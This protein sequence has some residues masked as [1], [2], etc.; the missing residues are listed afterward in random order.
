M[1]VIRN[2]VLNA[3]KA[4]TYCNINRY[5]R[6]TPYVLHKSIYDKFSYFH[7]L[8]LNCQVVTKITLSNTQTNAF[9]NT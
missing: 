9:T 4:H 7:H 1:K 5:L 2:G 6:T 3:F 8:K